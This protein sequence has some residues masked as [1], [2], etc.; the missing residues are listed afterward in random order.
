MFKQIWLYD[1]TPILLESI[2]KYQLEDGT[3]V[4]DVQKDIEKEVEIDGETIIEYQQAPYEVVTVF[5]YPKEYT[6][7][8]PED[9]L[10][11]PIFFDGEKWIGTKKEV[12]EAANPPEPT[13]N[14]SISNEE[15]QHLIED[16]TLQLLSLQIE[17]DEKK[18]LEN[19]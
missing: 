5:D 11:Q 2:Q 13:E 3:I 8:Q 7:L 16:L 18:V 9:G 14:Q 1:G 17:I 15:M 12:W 10:Y 19:E 4:D 6:E